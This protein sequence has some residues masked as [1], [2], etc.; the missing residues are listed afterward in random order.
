[1]L[2]IV[3]T[4]I[5][6]RLIHGQVVT[7]WAKV[8]KGNRIIV[9]DDGVAND[10]FMSKII[11]MAAPSS[12]KIGIHTIE[13]AAEILQQDDAGERVIVLAKTPMTIKTLMEKGVEIKDLDLGGMGATKGR[14]Q[15]YRNI[16]IS[17]E[18]KECFKQLIDKGVHVVVQ[19][20]PDDTPK[21][22]QSF[23]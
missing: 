15:L 11:K 19:I 21:D 1:M 7:A 23:F 9:V 6:D 20:V 4:R 17:E 22:I 18:E 8:T 5:D 12:F 2:N 3:L 10:D 13:Q 16:S 14:K